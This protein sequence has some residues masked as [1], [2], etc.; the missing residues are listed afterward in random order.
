M[1]ELIRIDQAIKLTTEFEQVS[2]EIDK[3]IETANSLVVSEDNYKEVKKI[4]AELNKE[5][6]QYAEDFKTIKES[7]LATWNECEDTYKKMI[8][9]KYAESDGILKS[10]VGEIEDGIKN[11]KREKIVEFFEKH[12]ASRKLDFVTFDDMNLKIGMS[13]SLASLKREVTEKLDEILKGYE[14]ALEISPDVVA[15]FK[16]NGFDFARAFTTVK[17]REERKRKAEEERKA[18]LEARAER[19]RKEAEAKAIVQEA[20]IKESDEVEEVA[21]VEQPSTHE[22][23]REKVYSVTFTVKGT[24]EELMDLS[25]FL[26]E[27]NYDYKQIK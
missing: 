10:K 12:R 14:G 16:E 15:E 7:V 22:E 25:N 1:A 19:E 4:R 8:R 23:E 26:K 3:K 13:N 24:R 18:M 17:D 5:A 9:D 20:E 6:K 11:E 2:K 21:E 27:L